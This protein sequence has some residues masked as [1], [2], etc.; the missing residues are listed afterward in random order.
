MKKT[1]TLINII[2]LLSLVFAVT[3]CDTDLAAELQEDQAAQGEAP[4]AEAAPGEID[5]AAIFTEAAA[6]VSAQITQTAAAFSPTP[7]PPTA[8]QVV[9]PTATLIQLDGAPTTDPASATV[10]PIG[11]IQAT[12]TPIA[13]ATLIPTATTVATINTQEGPVCDSMSYGDP[14][15]VT[16]PDESTVP[17]GHDFT[18]VWLVTNSGTCGW[19][20]GYIL[21]PVGAESTRPNDLNPLDASNPAALIGGTIAPGESTHLGVQLTAPLT[22][23]TYATHFVLQND[24]G[25]YFGGALTVI[26]KVVDGN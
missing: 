7:P 11:G 12:F 14:V 23:G 1:T 20:D 19:D 10:T 18:K 26:I 24:R 8:T 2:L 22:N 15:D 16:Y 5:P 17:A 6:T 3:A 21:V 13:G 25:S 9:L 4:A